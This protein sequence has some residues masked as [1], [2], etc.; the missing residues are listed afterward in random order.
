MVDE[1]EEDLLEG[2]YKFEEEYFETE[3]WSSKKGDQDL[4]I[5]GDLNV[6]FCSNQISKDPMVNQ[7]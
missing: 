4:R 3:I 6:E 1:F 5:I 7:G 2:K